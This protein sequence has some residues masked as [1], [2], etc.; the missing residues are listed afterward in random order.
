V[1]FEEGWLD[2]G[3][4]N[5]SS[6]INAWQLRTSGVALADVMSL[7]DPQ[8]YPIAPRISMA[9]SIVLGISYQD[10]MINRSPDFQPLCRIFFSDMSSD[11]V[12]LAEAIDIVNER[13]EKTVVVIEEGC[14]ER[15]VNSTNEP[16]LRQLPVT[17]SPNPFGTTTLLQF[18]NPAG[19]PYRVEIFDA[20]ARLV[21][22]YHD[23]RNGQLS[24]DR[25][26]LSAGVYSY[27][28]SGQNA[29]VTGKLVI[30]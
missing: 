27:R 3:I 7:V 23:I 2:I 1:N 24:I 18:P 5:P 14:A 26:Q 9:D 16:G 21:R 30:Q 28:L 25:N 22:Q 6:R 11:F 12:C 10:S 8:L 4:K 29:L 17:I 15:I 13:Q 19:H 20:N